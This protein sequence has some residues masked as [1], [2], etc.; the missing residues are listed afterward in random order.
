MASIP[1]PQP[2]DDIN[3][4]TTPSSSTP[5]AR[6]DTSGGGASVTTTNDSEYI[7][8]NTDSATAI[9]PNPATALPT[10]PGEEGAT[11]TAVTDVRMVDNT[12][13]QMPDVDTDFG[14][15]TDNHGGFEEANEDAARPPMGGDASRDPVPP[16]SP[17]KKQMALMAFLKA[18]GLAGGTPGLESPDVPQQDNGNEGKKERTVKKKPAGGTRKV[19]APAKSGR[20][21]ATSSARTE[22][23]VSRVRTDKPAST[24]ART[25]SKSSP[26]APLVEWIKEARDKALRPVLHG[27][28]QAS[29][30]ELWCTFESLLG[31][32]QMKTKSLTSKMRPP[33]VYAWT[34]RKHQ[35]ETPPETPPT[36]GA[37]VKLW[38]AHLQPEWRKDGPDKPLLRSEEP[39]EE[40]PE[41]MKA[42][43]NGFVL[44]VLALCWWLKQAVYLDDRADCF[45]VLEDVAWV[46]RQMVDKLQLAEDEMEDEEE[47]T[48]PAKRCD[49]TIGNIRS[50]PDFFF[51]TGA[52]FNHR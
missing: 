18:S 37:A 8:P 9:G 28:D 6:P 38:W 48:R 46:L 34:Q 3:P 5:P 1:A 20:K 10:P 21:A 25:R 2:V 4:N 12:Q 19:K 51:P 22:Q 24:V 43:K 44:I 32:A 52:A 11:A 47:G 30:I 13:G 15:P 31:P 41:L 49:S 45:S 33:Q 16:T 39:E 17:Q 23:A 27:T 36:F 26:T 7:H 42:G 50:L 40:W 35:Y 14:S 29:I